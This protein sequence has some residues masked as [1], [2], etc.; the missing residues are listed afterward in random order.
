MTQGRYAIP[1]DKALAIVDLLTEKVDEWV[2]KD[3]YDQ[4]MDEY[5]KL[6]SANKD[7]YEDLTVKDW[8][9]LES[10]LNSH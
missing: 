2:A 4:V 6:P 7:M 5:E 10:F 8:T 3:T 9:K 1:T